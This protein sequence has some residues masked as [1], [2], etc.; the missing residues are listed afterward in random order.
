MILPEVL[1]LI[2]FM[3]NAWVEFVLIWLYNPLAVAFR[4]VGWI[5]D[6]PRDMS[7]LYGVAGDIYKQAWKG[8]AEVCDR[9]AV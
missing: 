2:L 6:V 4:L 5:P 8:K 1:A 7:W 3:W 9:C